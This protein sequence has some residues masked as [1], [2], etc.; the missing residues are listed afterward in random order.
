MTRREIALHLLSEVR[1]NERRIKTKVTLVAKKMRKAKMKF[2]TYQQ[3]VGFNT[4]FTIYIYGIDDKGIDYAAG[5]WFRSEKGLCWVTSGQL[6]DVVFYTDHFFD[7]YAERYLK[8]SVNVLEAAREFYKEFKPTITR[9]TEKVTEG[10]YK[11]QLPLAIGGLALGFLDKNTNI[12]V[13]N[14][15][16]ST[17]TLYAQQINDVEADREL[18]EIIQTMDYSEWIM[19]GKTIKDDNNRI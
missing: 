16:V 1:S 19:I 7:R 9:L 14:T 17:D 12:I 11:V 10:V 3:N 15:Y 8:K 5:L 4:L 18:N 6:D 2:H 13:Y